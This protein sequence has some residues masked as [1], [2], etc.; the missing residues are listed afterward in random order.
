MEYNCIVSAASHGPSN[1][2]VVEYYG[3]FSHQH[4]EISK[5]RIYNLAHYRVPFSLRHNAFFSFA[6]YIR[7]GLVLPQRFIAAYGFAFDILLRKLFGCFTKHAVLRPKLSDDE[8]V[9]V[10]N[11]YAVCRF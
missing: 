11:V 6:G 2:C 7:E 9:N 5:R 3:H 10:P 4:V 1:S 8:I